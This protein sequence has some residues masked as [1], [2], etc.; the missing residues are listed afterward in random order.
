M[1]TARTGVRWAR[2]PADDLLRWF[3]ALDAEGLGDAYLTEVWCSLVWHAVRGKYRR[4]ALSDIRRLATGKQHAD[5]RA[6][7]AGETDAIR[8]FAALRLIESEWR[9]QA[10]SVRR[11]VQLY[12]VACG[13]D[14]DQ[15]RWRT[16]RL[17]LHG[18]VHTPVDAPDIPA[19]MEGYEALLKTACEPS[20]ETDLS[21]FA[22]LAAEL[23]THLIRTHPFPDGKGRTGRLLCNLALRRWRLP[24][25]D[26]PKVRNSEEWLGSVNEAIESASGGAIAGIL[27]E[28]IVTALEFARDYRAGLSLDVDNRRDGRR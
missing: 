20:G 1:S 12:A 6:V 5:G 14:L 25:I 21:R 7:S 15:V 26:L 10:L 11:V 3:R 18:G 13:C 19:A 8:Q 24:Y 9:H 16:D 22:G 27:E 28:H 2:G 17:S 23:F 4:L